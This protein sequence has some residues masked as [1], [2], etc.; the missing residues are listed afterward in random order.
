[1]S[2]TIDTQAPAAPVIVGD[3]VNGNNITF[4]GT[5]AASTT[6][7]LYDGQTVLGTTIANGNGAWSYTTGTLT[8]GAQSFTA[9]A[10]DV[11]GNV[12]A[13]SNTVGLPTTVIQVNGSTNLTEIANRFYLYNGNGSGPLLKFGGANVVAGQFG[14]STPIGAVQTSTGYDVA[15]EIPGSNTFTVWSVDNNG[16][17]VSNLLGAVSGTSTALEAFEPIFGQD[18]NGDG[19]IGPPSPVPTVSSFTPDNGIA[20]NNLTTAT[21]LTLNG[22]AAAANS[23]VTVYDGLTALGT[24]TANGNGAWSFTTGTLTNGAH[25]FTA[26]DTISV[27]NVSQS[28]AALTVSVDTQPP[29]APVIVSDAV[30]GNNITFA[31]TAEAN[32]T[33]TLYDGQ[34]VLGTTIANGNGAWSYTTGTLTNGAQSFTATSAN[35]AGISPT[36]N[37]IGLPTTVVQVDGS[38][39]LTEIANRFYLYNGNGS[40]PLFKYGGANVVAGQFGGWTPIGAV[41]TSTG[42]DVAWEIPGSNTFTVWSL[43]NNGNY[44]ST[45][46]GSTLGTSTA[47]QA[48][49]PIFGQDLNGDGVI[50]PPAPVPTINSFTPDTGIVGDDITNATILTLNGT[51]AAA[52]STVTVYDGLT[53]LGTTTANGNGAWSFTTGTLTNGSHSFTAT[54]T[55][56]VG[57]VSHASVALSVTIDTQAPAAP[58]IVGD[59][60]NGNNITFTG[61][62]AASTTVTLYD[63]QTVLGTTIANG[64]GAWSYTTGT[65]TNGA[66]SFTATAT[67][68]AG[69]VSAASNTVGL[70]TTVIQVNGS[71]NLTEIAN[72]FYLYNGN[73][74]GPLLKFGGANV[75]AGQFGGFTPIGAVQTSTGYDVAWEIPGSNTFTVWSVDNN[76]NYV[77]N[78]LGAVSGTS[79]AL[80]AFEPI[81]GQD[82][83]GDGVIGPPS[84][85]PTVSSFTPDNGI[86]ANNLTTATILTLNG[87]AAAPNSTVTVYDGLTA[88]GTTTANG[89]G[90]WS[91][92]TGTLT[93]GAHS[94]TAT[95][96]ISV[97]NVSQS[98]AALTVSIDTQPPA[99]PVIVSDAVNGNNTEHSMAPLRLTAPS[100]FTTNNHR[101]MRPSSSLV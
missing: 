89:N 35:L 68:V 51:A 16:N 50:G 56:S 22:G 95:D 43:D 96:T 52:N 70:P 92:T 42:Y 12:S 73:G 65:L 91:F 94:F 57:N 100:Q 40:G 47:L 60:V 69:N 81:F 17:Y 98:S 39:N 83:N 59:A 99:A 72:R 37:A 24:T 62:A 97:G 45:L 53:A 30:N 82:L 71:T 46:L 87:G 8:N 80:E 36:S 41:Q 15:W 9:T 3:A 32:N 58:V 38:T 61:T 85:V 4:T 93:N 28:S 34:T 55:I 54:D 26:T 25:S 1:M 66:Q 31:G 79:T 64:N 13:A 76:G 27:G 86:A 77:S 23:T 7:T 67:D 18:L 90:A 88:L 33:V 74:S 21:I 84:P 19:V 14:G 101:R 10:T 48:F 5:A 29:A 20:A 44:V 11:A 2:V 6:V 78:L 49:E 75:V 63:G